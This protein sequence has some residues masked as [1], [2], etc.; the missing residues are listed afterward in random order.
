LAFTTTFGGMLT[1]LITVGLGK[2]NYL[3]LLS[4]SQIKPNAI[5]LDHE[6]L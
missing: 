6:Q 1:N 5:F 2:K 3:Y 4:V